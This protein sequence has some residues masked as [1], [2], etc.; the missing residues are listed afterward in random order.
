MK[1]ND[2]EAANEEQRQVPYRR[3]IRKMTHMFT[4]IYLKI[5]QWKLHGNNFFCSPLLLNSFK[6]Y[7]Y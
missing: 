5:R 1:N 4:T 2:N 7:N 6:N 3:R